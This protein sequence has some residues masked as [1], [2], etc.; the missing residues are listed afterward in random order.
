MPKTPAPISNVSSKAPKAS[1]LTSLAAKLNLFVQNLA[2]RGAPQTAPP[3]IQIH[4]HWYKKP[5]LVIPLVL[6]SISYI[7]LNI[8]IYNR[9]EDISS[10][11]LPILSEFIK[12]P[13][14]KNIHTKDSDLSSANLPSQQDDKKTKEPKSTPAPAFTLKKKTEVALASEVR[15]DIPQAIDVTIDPLSKESKTYAIL[16]SAHDSSGVKGVTLTIPSDK[17]PPRPLSLV[18]GTPQDGVWR[19]DTVLNFTGPT[20]QLVIDVENAGART[21]TEVSVP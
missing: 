15:D 19:T 6:V 16:V 9:V 13:F 10:I 18:K 12:N 17:K 3:Y 8:W 14:Q 20:I 7:Y 21:T 11:K 2:S 5:K 4:P 1:F